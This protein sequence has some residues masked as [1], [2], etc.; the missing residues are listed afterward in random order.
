VDKSPVLRIIDAN[1]NR[2]RE[3]L[4]VIEEYCRFALDDT[5]Q[6]QRAKRLRHNVTDV[7]SGLAESREL[8]GSRDSAAD[9]GV[10]STVPSEHERA[11]LRHV[12]VAAFKRVEEG[13]RVLEEYS[14][15][16]P[17]V[18]A[19]ERFKTL[20]FESYELEKTVQM[21]EETGP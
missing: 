6:T 1:A 11:S 8:L 16:L 7:V 4:R 17:A 20:R 10:E 14:K 19:S 12:V 15:L 5:E 21:N 3:G 2:V 9:V 13:L 18:G